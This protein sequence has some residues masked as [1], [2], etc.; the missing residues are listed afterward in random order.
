MIARPD[1]TECA[2]FYR[3][4]LNHVPEGDV[5]EGMRRQASDTA[6]LWRS[7]SAAQA[8]HRY[9]SGKWSVKEVAAHMI[10]TE[11]IFQS[12][13]LRFA[14]SDQTPLPGYDHDAYVAALDLSH[15]SMESLGGEFE[16]LRAS[17]LDLFGG[18]TEDELNRSGEA[19]GRAI[20]VR[21][22]VFIVAGHERHHMG[23]LRERYL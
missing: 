7:L 9:A 11:R 13:A 6:A 23:V 5:L 14:R 16:R 15:R 12:R 17:T 20:T 19:S 1:P 3:G 4:Y 21:A 18:F 10:D 8:K 22:I 2:P